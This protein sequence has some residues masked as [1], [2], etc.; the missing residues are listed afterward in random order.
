MKKTTFAILAA[1]ILP[2]AARADDDRWLRVTVDGDE[3]TVRINLPIAVV[4]AAM[5]LVQAHAR[6]A[7]VRLDGHDFD[8]A[9]LKRLLVALN[10]AKDGEYVTV[11]DGDDHVRVAKE[12]KFLTVH[13]QEKHA[14]AKQDDNVQ[15]RMP[16]EVV[17]ALVSGDDDDDEL[18][19]S[20][21]LDALAKFGS[22]DLVTVKDDGDLVRIWIDQKSAD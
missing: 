19:L 13:A 22:G 18:N 8:R 1:L 20:A 3:V 6:D 21:A 16:L 15:V 10:E 2:L 5:P 14:G 9:D 12:G 4:S 17:A 7:E 11:D